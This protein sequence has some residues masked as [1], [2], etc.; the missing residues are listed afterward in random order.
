MP[1]QTNE[2]RKRKYDDRQSQSLAPSDTP[3]VLSNLPALPPAPSASPPPNSQQTQQTGAGTATGVGTA[4]ATSTGAASLQH[5]QGSP[6]I[7]GAASSAVV[8]GA[9]TSGKSRPKRNR[10]KAEKKDDN[11]KQSRFH[12]DYCGK[13]LSF[14]VRARCAVCPDYDS[15]L[16]CF[17]VG[18]ALLPHR[19]DH[20]YRLVEVVHTPIYQHGWSADEEEK[21]L[22]G[23][24][25]YG[26]GNWE[27]VA[28]VIGTKS[29]HETENHFLT[30][31]LESS[32]APLP[33]PTQLLSANAGQ[34]SEPHNDVDPKS[35]RVMHKHQQEDA[36]GWMPKREDFVYEWDNDAED[37]I[38][39]M[40][41][42][43]DDISN[44]KILR[45]RVMEIYCRKLD[46][47]ER[48]KKFVI[49]R[50]LTDVKGHEENQKK[51]SVEERDL[52]ANLK[53]FMRFVPKEDFEN[54]INGITAESEIRSKIDVMR[55]GRALGATSYEESQRLLLASG[56]EV[57]RLSI[58]N[59]ASASNPN[60]TGKCLPS[61][62]AGGEPSVHSGISQRRPRR[63]AGENSMSEVTSGSAVFGTAQALV[64]PVNNERAFDPYSDP[65][66][67]YGGILPKC[68]M[69][70]RPGVELL[71]AKEISL[72]ETLK[73]VPHQYMIVKEAM[74]RMSL[75]NGQLRKKEARAAIKIDHTKVS[76]I[77]DYL[78][79]CGWIRGGASGVAGANVT[80]NPA[81]GVATANST[82]AANS[83][84]GTGV[85]DNRI[86]SGISTSDTHRAS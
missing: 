47:R 54:F 83:V 59:T 23:L 72:C 66:D 9:A 6:S 18:A 45:L 22:E 52:R 34:P 37:I 28:K 35:L 36:A 41:I 39:D 67:R 75:R 57:S 71:S 63:S 62:P 33:D 56:K 53:V 42:C 74:L 17:S 40:E 70:S 58:A 51:L 84:G 25:I 7:T 64:T 82:S 73:I 55:Q 80:G 61:Q 8:S 14:S 81:S 30:V 69:E 1:P 26:I 11:E 60:N 29:P 16:D 12:C 24:E 85:P 13:D 32:N 20:D 65:R 2:N 44:E 21:L 3:S 15:C 68:D 31:Y 76:K 19:A 50:N 48:R 49:D 86:T 78:L 27:Q 10:S 5:P 79:G 46:E 38:G 77:Y 4:A 43:D